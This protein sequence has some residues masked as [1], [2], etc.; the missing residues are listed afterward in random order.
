MKAQITPKDFDLPVKF[1]E[2]PDFVPYPARDP[3]LAEVRRARQS[4]VARKQAEGLNIAPHVLRETLGDPESSY[5]ARRLVASSLIG[6]GW[7]SGAQ[8]ATDVGRRRAKLFDFTQYAPEARPGTIEVTQKG[9]VYLEDTLPH[10]DQIV[11]AKERKLTRH[12][13]TRQLHIARRF[14]NGALILSAANV[15]NLAADNPHLPNPETQQMVKRES[16]DT[17][18]YARDLGIAL[19]ATVSLVQ[20]AE[21]DSPLYVHIR[22][23]APTEVYNAY[24]EAID[25][26]VAA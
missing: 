5:H 3:A 11:L 23:T 18:A 17:F 19:Q 2:A 12:M 15:A 14:T 6:S 7:H 26:F 13:D 16:L 20:L 9:I 21:P 24:T 4:L 22:R 25:M 8:H 1:T 10:A